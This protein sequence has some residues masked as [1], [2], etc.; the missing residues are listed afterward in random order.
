VRSSTIARLAR[1]RAQARSRLYELCLSLTVSAV[2][3]REPAAKVVA[4]KK[5]RGR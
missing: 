3:P 2:R 4:F 5:P 1:A